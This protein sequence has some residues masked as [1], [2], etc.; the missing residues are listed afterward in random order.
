MVVQMIVK[1]G[2]IDIDVGVSLL[3]SGKPLGSGDNAHEFD[4]LGVALLY[5]GDSVDCRAAGGKH[6]IKDYN[7]THLYIGRQLA[8]ILN[9]H[10]RF[11]VSV[12][13]DMTD[14]C[15]GNERKH[16]VHHAETGS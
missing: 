3:K 5:L 14:S 4:I 1:S 16:A 9:R 12:K 11:G 7:L 10:K 13:A 15:G 2:D 6:R 8:V